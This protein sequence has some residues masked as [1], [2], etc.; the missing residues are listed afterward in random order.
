MDK[1]PSN[2]NNEQKK[3]KI[4]YLVNEILYRKQNILKNIGTNRYPVWTLKNKKA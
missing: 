2:L 1:L 4:K 3:R